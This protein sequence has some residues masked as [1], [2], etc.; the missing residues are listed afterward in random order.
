MADLNRSIEELENDFWGEPEFGSYVVRTCHQARK[1]PIRLLSAEEIRCL[2]G[3]KIGL[4]YLLPVAVDLLQHDP[5]MDVTYFEGDL[6]LTLL[7]LDA[8]DW[9]QNP[10]AR[11]RFR[12]ILQS[13]RPQIAACSDIPEKLLEQ[14]GL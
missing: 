7:R 3:Q 9:E 12:T 14:Y 5:L 4:R 10:D 1:K 11:E 8:A 6:L 13:N 2:T